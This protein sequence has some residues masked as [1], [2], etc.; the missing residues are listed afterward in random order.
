MNVVPSKDVPATPGA[1]TL[2]AEQKAQLAEVAD[3]L[4]TIYETLVK[5]RYVDPKA[6]VRGPHEL[7][8]DLLSLYEK[9]GLDP[10]VIYL[11]SI[12]P[13][14]NEAETE[15]R[16]FFQGGAFF[17]QMKAGDVTQGRDPC[18]AS[19]RGDY[20]EEDG[21]YIYPWYT[22]LSNCGNHSPIIIYDA[23]E[24]RIWII[25]QIQRNATDPYYCKG[26]YEGPEGY[27]KKEEEETWGDSGESEWSDDGDEDEEDSTEMSDSH[28]SSEFWDDEGEVVP[29]QE[30]DALKEDLAE[31]VEFD[32]G[33]E[34]VEEL[35][36]WERKEA[37]AIKNDNSLDLIRFRPAVDVLRDINQWYMELKELPG[38]GE[39][40]GWLEPS[41]L[42]PLY[43]QNGWLDQF[44]G[45]QFEIDYA[46]A[47]GKKRAQYDAENPIRQLECV[48]GWDEYSKR[49]VAQHEKKIADAKTIEEEWQA[50]FELR[51]SK[52]I[53]RRNLQDIENNKVKAEKMCPGGVAQRPEDLPLWEL[54]KLRVELRWKNEAVARGPNQ[55]P[56]EKDP[57]TLRW[58][59]AVYRQKKHQKEVYEKAYQAAKADAE[60]LCPGRTFYE[61]TGRRSLGR[62]DTLTQ[63]ESTKKTIKVIEKFGEVLSEFAAT[64]PDTAPQTKERVQKEIERNNESVKKVQQD[65]ERL[66]TSLA[67]DG[68]RDD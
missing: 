11:Y 55:N 39:Y 8:K 19:P 18:Y 53:E 54:E 45:D 37:L 44:N 14:I 27:N 41:I 51:K 9:E 38:Q 61:A 36:E 43:V 52:E 2:S 47:Y 67:K 15:A 16:D 7:S 10:A 24:H 5:M 3:A 12:M 35:S 4:L 64:I 62:Q 60:R 46:R 6:L 23:R 40:S 17:S 31:D 59:D 49:E 28:G 66:E 68:N 20:H 29:P 65:L 58:L 1:D 32:E 48:Q 13:Y 21:K 63:I 30:L 26:W 22:P 25:D 56:T 50:R 34:H 42:K 57:E 33:F